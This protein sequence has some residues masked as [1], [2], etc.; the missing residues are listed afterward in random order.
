MRGIFHFCTVS[1]KLCVL[2]A[3]F[4]EGAMESLVIRN[5]L[6]DFGK[7]SDL[8]E[9]FTGA[10]PHLEK[11][12][13][14]C[15]KR[16]FDLGSDCS[17]H[18]P[19]SSSDGLTELIIEGLDGEQI[20][21]EI[22][23]TNGPL[24]KQAVRDIARLLTSRA[25]VSLVT[26]ATKEGGHCVGTREKY[27]SE[28]AK[29]DEGGVFGGSQDLFAESQHTATSCSDSSDQD[30]NTDFD[31]RDLEARAKKTMVEK[32]STRAA[33]ARSPRG[34]SSVVDDEFFKLSEM[35][36]FLEM[37]DAKEERRRKREEA[38]GGEE[39]EQ[40]PGED[41]E[42]ESVDL[43]DDMSSDEEESARN[44]R[45]G[46]YFDSDNQNKPSAKKGIRFEEI[47]EEDEDER[48]DDDI[49]DDGSFRMESKSPDEDKAGES[50]DSD[51]EE[52]DDCGDNG[53]SEGEDLAD[54]LGGR[55]SEKR[56]TFE[57]RQEKLKQKI[58]R[59]EEANLSEKPWQLSGE[60]KGTKRPENSLLQEDLDFDVTTKPAPVITEETTQ[61]LEDI[62]RQRILDRAWDDVERKQRRLEEPYEFKKRI[63]LDQE[64]SKQSLAEIY[65]KEYLKQ[66]EQEKE[67]EENPAHTEIKTMMDALF[68]KLDALS[69]FHYM[70][71]PVAP[72]V[73]IVK[74]VPSISMEEVAP[75]TATGATLLAPEEIQEKSKAELKGDTERTAS[76][77]KQALRQKKQRQRTR[78]KEKLKKQRAVE[79][80]KPGMGNKYSAK[81]ALQ[82]LEQDSKLPSSKMTI[83]KDDRKEKMLKSS[84][85]FFGRLQDE[86]TSEIRGVKTKKKA[87][88][89]TVSSKKLKL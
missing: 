59:L 86:V 52:D 79:K 72:E 68:V 13:T 80:L 31:I 25:G 33:Q 10:Q 8:P 9:N 76:D 51:V 58:E 69:N 20:W 85:S 14:E 50:D 62:I 16:L 49:D 65:E 29:S 6:T 71:R 63:T 43:F 2:S 61:A 64:K 84:K 48:S 78:A 27:D 36:R 60:V 21:E 70:P 4:F 89:Q 12:F 53:D 23:L 3:L 57:K 32:L 35:E 15:A 38:G 77:R 11:P 41:K 30:S 7:N 56:S 42:A 47:G 24:L 73:K 1:D 17:I 44:M 46:D 39:E 82:R 54:I 81:S 28:E 22:E 67:D 74:N 5:V 88:K 26:T 19:L 45:Y 18:K 75:I 37:E 55:A 83:I 87:P 34:R 40:D 66:A